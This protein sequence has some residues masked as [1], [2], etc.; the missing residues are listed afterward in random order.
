MLKSKKIL[1]IILAVVLLLIIP[2]VVN[3]AVT[4][5]TETTETS[6]G[7]VV[8]WSYELSDNN[9]TNLRCTNVDSVTGSLTIPS[10]I[11]GYTVTSLYG[12]IY[13]AFRNCTGLTSV[14]IPD[15]VTSIGSNAFEDCTGLT[16]I[17]IPD[18]VTSIGSSAFSGC[19]GLRSITIP[20][21][22]TSI[23]SYAFRGCTGLTS[24]TLSANLTKINRQTFENCSA[25]TEISLPDNL[26]TIESTNEGIYSAFSDCTS[27]KYIRIPENVVSIG[28]KAFK[29]C[30]DLIIFGKAGSVAEEYATNNNIDFEPIENWDNRYNLSGGDD[31]NDE[32][33]IDTTRYISFPMMIINGKGT[34]SLRSGVYDGEYTMYYQF[35]EVSDEVY[36]NLED[37]KEQYE[38]EEITYEEFLTQLN[39]N[40]TQYDESNWIETEDG[41]FEQDLSQ[42]TGTKKFALWVKL[43]ME[44][45]TVY[46]VNVYTMN[47]SGSATTEDPDSTNN[48]GVEE[49][50]NKGD[51]NTKDETI[52]DKE[53][54]N[55]GKVI[56]A[57]TIAVVAIS[58]IVAHIR[59]KKLYM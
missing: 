21:S 22:V 3:G 7:A 19:S 31:N 30:E 20:D 16:S 59:Y 18:S 35:V 15:S 40:V 28:A 58:A 33:Q 5:A 37:L 32:E 47:G 27:L 34:L 48:P 6:T 10:T 9:A 46:E 57:W 26:T 25:L 54:P 39:N 13:G 52:A 29:D 2:T 8:N 12:S 43:E 49:D 4:E 1:L 53:L 56:L 36:S 45:K 14:I 23:E 42:F 50:T 41:S 44:D 11:D 55:T 51:T 38:N 24:I 17:T